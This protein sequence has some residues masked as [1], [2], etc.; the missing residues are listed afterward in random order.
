LASFSRQARQFSYDIRFT[1]NHEK[2]GALD[3]D[4]LGE[5]SVETLVD[6]GLVWDLADIYTLAKE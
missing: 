1:S 2:S 5:K 4:T 6:A 3:I